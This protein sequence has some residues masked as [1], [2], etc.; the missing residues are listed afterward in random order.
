MYNLAVLLL[1]LSLG[2]LLQSH[3]GWTYLTLKMKLVKFNLNQFKLRHLLIK[4][5]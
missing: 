2:H 5:I 1:C 4:Y 3:R